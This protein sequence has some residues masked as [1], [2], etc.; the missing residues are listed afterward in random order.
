M[1]ILCSP[2]IAGGTV[3]AQWLIMSLRVQGSVDISIQGLV[4][5]PED[6]Y[7]FAVVSYYSAKN[8]EGG[9]YGAFSAGDRREHTSLQLARER[10]FSQWVDNPSPLAFDAS[11]VGVNLTLTLREENVGNWYVLA[12]LL[13]RPTMLD[14]SV[15]PSDALESF[16]SGTGGVHAIFPHDFSAM[17]DAHASVGAGAIYNMDVT[18]ERGLIGGFNPWFGITNHEGV[19]GFQGPDSSDKCLALTLVLTALADCH[20]FPLHGGPG[21]WSFF[22]SQRLDQQ[23]AP[24]DLWLTYIDQAPPR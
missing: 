1:L 15:S 24:D 8:L 14:V 3:E 9:Y 4:N 16:Q 7:C 11:P 23:A 2:A 22:R 21:A 5:C 19:G 12:L 10:I 13:S 20:A 17:A 6:P 18:A